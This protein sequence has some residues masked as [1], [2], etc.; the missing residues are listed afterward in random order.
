MK[1]INFAE[2]QT[3]VNRYM[4]E[5]RDYAYRKTGRGSAAIWKESGK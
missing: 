4:S 2:Q 1:V 3:V 5:L